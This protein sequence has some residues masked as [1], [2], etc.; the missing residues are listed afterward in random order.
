MWFREMFS[1]SISLAVKENYHKKDAAKIWAVL[2]RREYCDSRKV[3][4]NRSFFALKEA[5][6]LESISSK[7]FERS[8]WSFF[9]KCSKFHVDFKNAMKIPKVLFGFQDNCVWTGFWNLFQLWGEYMWSTVNVLTKS[10]YVLDL[11]QGDVFQL[12]LS[13]IKWRLG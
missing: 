2:A 1:N 10:L 13:W 3:F 7:V 8:S 11:I 5:H 6:I 9:S 12:N 4:W